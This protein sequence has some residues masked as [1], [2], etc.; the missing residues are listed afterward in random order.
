MTANAAARLPAA[1]DPS[2]ACY[3]LALV[4]LGNICRSPM[5]HVVLDAK[6]AQERL[7]DSVIVTSSGTGDWHIGEPMDVRA[8]TALRAHGY[9]ATRHR[10]RHF[11]PDWIASR[12][13]L[14]VMDAGN[15]RD[16]RRLDPS[17]ADRERVLMFRAFDPLAGADVELPDP[18]YGDQ[19][20]FES[21]LD[22]I[23]R[24]CE[25]LVRQLAALRS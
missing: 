23:A 14:L 13:A 4:C 22:I 19:R 2:A 1:R 7:A 11:T 10:A 6:L 17:G 8:A 25:E 20:G 9:D 5:A 15:W 18:W 21:V 24:T 3:E 16:V 12:D